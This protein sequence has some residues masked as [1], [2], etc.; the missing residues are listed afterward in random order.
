[1]CSTTP[2]FSYSGPK[3][4][5]SGVGHCS[6]G[7][8]RRV[9]HGRVWYGWG[10]GGWVV[11]VGNTGAQRRCSRRVHTSE[12]GPGSSC[13]ELEWVG[14]GPD[15]LGHARTHPSGARSA[16]QASLVLPA[17]NPASW[18]ITARFDLISQDISQNSEVSPKS[19]QKACHSP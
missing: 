14:V 19:T 7:H 6:N 1:M 3:L 9:R 10:M 8:V 5:V 16:L 17:A 2:R 13:R 11:R 12:A 18:P 15:V 4:R